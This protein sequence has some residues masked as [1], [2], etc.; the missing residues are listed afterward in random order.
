M[1]LRF[2]FQRE[3]TVA[4]AT[5]GKIPSVNIEI[6]RIHEKK[7]TWLHSKQ[8][9]QAT[10]TFT[11]DNGKIYHA[12]LT[13]FTYDDLKKSEDYKDAKKVLLEFSETLGL[14]K[15]EAVW[16]T[17]CINEHK[18]LKYSKEA[19]QGFIFTSAD[20]DVTQLFKDYL[21]FDHSFTSFFDVG[22]F[23]E[24]AL[25]RSEQGEDKYSEWL[26]SGLKYDEWLKSSNA[27]KPQ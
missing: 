22:Y 11:Y 26:Q 27:L 1:A 2:N 4:L 20:G 25:I 13:V 5:S 23:H 24:H 18:L 14:G 7:S 19:K 9:D 6:K 10:I 12:E 3:S 21:K 8:T 17:K 15:T 16:K